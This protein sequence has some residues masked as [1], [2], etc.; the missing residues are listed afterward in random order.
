VIC[1]RRN[2]QPIVT[3]DPDDLAHLDPQARLIVV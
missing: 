3:S 2:A 1:A